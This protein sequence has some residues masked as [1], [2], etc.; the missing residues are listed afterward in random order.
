MRVIFIGD[1]TFRSFVL[2]IFVLGWERY[3]LFIKWV[4]LLGYLEDN[5]VNFTLELDL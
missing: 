3:I 4:F 5:L 2:V 1:E